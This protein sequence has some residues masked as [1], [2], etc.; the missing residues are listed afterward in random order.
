V[1]RLPLAA[2]IHDLRDGH[3]NAACGKG[4]VTYA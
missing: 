2:A 3:S 1:K 4:P